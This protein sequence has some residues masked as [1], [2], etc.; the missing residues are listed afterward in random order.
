MRAHVGRVHVSRNEA[1]RRPVLR[2]TLEHGVAAG[3]MGIERGDE[4][5][6]ELERQRPDETLQDQRHVVV[7]QQQVPQRPGE[8]AA[9]LVLTELPDD[10]MGAVVDEHLAQRLGIVEKPLAQQVELLV[11]DLESFRGRQLL[12]IAL[13]RRRAILAGLDPRGTAVG[14]AVTGS[15]E[16]DAE[17]KN[18]G[19]NHA[20]GRHGRGHGDFPE[21]TEA[22]KDRFFRNGPIGNHRQQGQGTAVDA[23]GRRYHALRRYDLF[24]DIGPASFA[25]VAVHLDN[26]AVLD[27]DL[28]AATGRATDTRTDCARRVMP[29]PLPPVRPCARVLPARAPL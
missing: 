11:E 13:R 15:H 4:L 6:F 12:R 22:G 8:L 1:L 17:T 24:R 2:P 10:G 23:D 28:A 3:E 25:G 20:V 5:A 9:E 29:F 27:D 18:V 21:L 19:Q 7:A 26:D 16:V 14:R